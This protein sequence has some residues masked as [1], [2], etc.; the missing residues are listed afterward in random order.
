MRKSSGTVDG[1]ASLDW[2][3]RLWRAAE[4]TAA[5]A[6]A[7]GGTVGRLTPPPPPV[8]FTREE[9]GERG[10]EALTAAPTLCCFGAPY[11]GGETTATPLGRLATDLTTALGMGLEGRTALA[12]GLRISETGMGLL[13]RATEAEVEAEDVEGA[14]VEGAPPRAC[15]PTMASMAMARAS[16]GGSLDGTFD[17]CCL[18]PL[19]GPPCLPPL[20]TEPLPP[21]EAAAG[22]V[23]AAAAMVVTALSGAP[24]VVTSFPSAVRTTVIGAVGRRG[25][26]PAPD[27]ADIAIGCVGSCGTMA[28]PGCD[29]IPP[30]VLLS[31]FMMC[32]LGCLRTCISVPSGCR[33][34]CS[35]KALRL[36]TFCGE[37]GSAGDPA[38]A[39]PALA[40]ERPLGRAMRGGDDCPPGRRGF[41]PG[42]SPA[43]AAAATAPGGMTTFLTRERAAGG[44][45]F[46]MEAI[47]DGSEA[48]VTGAPGGALVMILWAEVV[49]TPRGRAEMGRG[50]SWC[51]F[52]PPLLLTMMP[53]SAF[54]A[55]PGEPGFRTVNTTFPGGTTAWAPFLP[56]APPEK[57]TEKVQIKSFRK[58]GTL[59]LLL[60]FPFP[61]LCLCVGVRSAF[62]TVGGI[63]ALAPLLRG[64]LAGGGRGGGGGHRL[65][66]ERG[67]GLLTGLD[68]GV[69]L[70]RDLDEGVLEKFDLQ[71]VRGVAHGGDQRLGDLHLAS[72]GELHDLLGHLKRSGV[73]GEVH[74]FLQGERGQ[75]AGQKIRDGG[76]DGAVDTEGWVRLVCGRISIGLGLGRRSL[77]F[78][79]VRLL[80]TGLLV[81]VLV[82]VTGFL[83]FLS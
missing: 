52:G 79:F 75:E 30:F 42:C 8:A 36:T 3:L 33:M 35:W 5:A 17:P 38:C 4:M 65:G 10:E 15:F 32:P 63:L 23:G 44:R 59:S 27:A 50:C 72:V 57:V 13:G 25:R 28:A 43:A 47:G 55:A 9:E 19:P 20:P 26:C 54:P 82:L 45:G 39:P 24:E 37:V 18:P 67:Q 56:L 74:V 81:L 58:I 68:G 61:A 16:L 6:A 46:F 77:V 21:P 12:P 80:V 41:C 29:G 51:G 14:E 11:P 34:V 62:L 71:P 49:T 78:V 76:Q 22:T 64:P 31:C 66:L 2:L 40:G 60:T 1:M 73:Q 70:V 53:G 83:V 69:I 7:V 48:E